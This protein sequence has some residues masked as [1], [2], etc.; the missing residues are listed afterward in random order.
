MDNKSLDVANVEDAKQKVS[1]I[2]VIGD[3]DSFKVFCKASSES[4]GWMKSTKVC[5]LPN[6]CLVQVSTQQ[7]NQDGHYAVAEALTF[8]PDINMYIKNT[9]DDIAEKD[10]RYFEIL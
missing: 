5:N 6:G 4:Q 1:D 10:R 9:N 8:V 3:G 7:R 2:K